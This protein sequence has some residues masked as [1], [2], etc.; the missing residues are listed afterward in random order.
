MPKRIQCARELEKEAYAEERYAP[1]LEE[2]KTYGCGGASEVG[3]VGLRTN[4]RRVRQSVARAL[5]QDG[6]RKSS[7]FFL[8]PNR[9]LSLFTTIGLVT[10][11]LSGLVMWRW[12]KPDDVLGAP[13]L[14]RPV[15]FSAGL[16]ALLVA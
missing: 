10:L 1:A 3:A 6:A 13:A 12:R 4:R 16:I 7:K 15:R 5:R 9:M 2:R 14:I 8:P 11:S